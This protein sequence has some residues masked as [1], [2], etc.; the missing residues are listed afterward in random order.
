MNT[1][2]LTATCVAAALGALVSW[3]AS[4][5]GQGA[6]EAIGA[7]PPAERAGVETQM[8]LPGDFHRYFGQKTNQWKDSERKIAKLDLDADMNYDGTI[9]NDDPRDNGAFQHT[10]PGL[11]VGVG[12]MSKFIVRLFPYRVDF[13]G[14]V[15]VGLD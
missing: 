15:V 14:S 1:K 3:P 12:E 8:D 11:I 5:L 6:K 4:S 2:K 10:P 9:D 13:R 7:A